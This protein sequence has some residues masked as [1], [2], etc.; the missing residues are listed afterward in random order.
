MTNFDKE[1]EF[2]LWL[3]ESKGMTS[4][5]AGDA[6][7]RLRRSLRLVPI[8]TQKNLHEY[9]IQLDDSSLLNEIPQSSIS[10]MKRAIVLYLEFTH[11]KTIR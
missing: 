1:K 9:L 11:P 2:K 6:V 4:K 8:T 10:S 7:S 5:A 3:E